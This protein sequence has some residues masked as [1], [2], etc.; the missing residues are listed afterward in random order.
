[1]TQKEKKEQRYKNEDAL[2]KAMSELTNA[3]HKVLDVIELDSDFDELTATKYP[4]SWSFDETVCE[5]D[6][7]REAVEEEIQKKRRKD[8]TTDK[9]KP[10]KNQMRAYVN[11]QRFGCTNM[12][13]FREVCDLAGNGLTREHC[14]Y[15]VSG[16]N[17]EDLCK[18]YGI[19]C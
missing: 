7:W 3:F 12:F 6:S 11:V 19:E 8:M 17:Y 10:T 18:E 15:I 4:F 2:I 13:N 5:V 1:M 16:N 14:L 9:I